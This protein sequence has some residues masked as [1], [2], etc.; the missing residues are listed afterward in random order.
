MAQTQ[1]SK[2]QIEGLVRGWIDGLAWQHE[3]RRA[4]TGGFDY[5]TA[6]EIDTLGTNDARELEGL[7]RFGGEMHADDQKRA[8]AGVLRGE[9]DLGAFE[10]IVQS[11]A[12]AI[13]APA[14]G[15]TLD[16]RLLTRTILRGYA[17]F[18]DEIRETV[19]SIPRQM[20][21][22]AIV[23]AAIPEFPL[24]QFWDD[25]ERHKTGRKEWK[26]DTAS[27]ARGTRNVFE[28]LFPGVTVAEVLSK[29]IASDFKTKVLALP[30]QYAQGKWQSMNAAQIA[31]DMEG[32]SI[33]TVHVKT[34]NKHFGNLSGYWQFLVEKKHISAEIKNPFEGYYTSVNKG[35]AARNERFNWPKQLEAKFFSAPW[36]TGC[37]SIYRR[38][39][40]GTEIHRDALLY[41]ASFDLFAA[42]ANFDGLRHFVLRPLGKKVAA[43]DLEDGI[44]KFAGDYNKYVGPLVSKELIEP[45]LCVVH[46]RYDLALGLFDLHAHCVWRVSPTNVDA[47]YKGIQ[48]KFSTVWMDKK[49]IRNP[50]ALVNYLVTWVV[51]HRQ[52]PDW[53]DDAL[54]ALWRASRPRL[55]RP[56]G[57]F[58]AFRGT[59]GDHRFVREGGTVKAIPVAKRR[60]KRKTGGAGPKTGAVVGF[61]RARLHG[62][63]RW[64]AIAAVNG[65]DRLSRKQIS[66]IVE[67]STLAKRRAKPSYPTTTTGLT[68][69]SPGPLP[70]AAQ[71]TPSSARISEISAEPANQHAQRGPI[72]AGSVVSPHIEHHKKV[73]SFLSF[74]AK[75]LA[76]TVARIYRSL[77]TRLRQPQGP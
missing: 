34:T 51:D 62:E 52:L 40:P 50:A 55:I 46:V 65:R 63:L 43:A 3:I 15:A 74:H 53:P 66:N 59:F 42:K 44:R 37:Q 23:P 18:L 1:F 19:A 75:R 7:L 29:P 6:A 72:G 48:T 2:V 36:I 60:A 68:P 22:A 12:R 56:A 31:K 4:E 71:M 21:S 25:F 27:N 30:R 32:K 67:Q 16:G 9:R 41:A 58:A 57:A 28:K 24:L 64:C 35:K 20:S 73:R 49:R 45:I 33:L 26:G 77:R 38:G 5:L 76:S 61:V 13:N 54:L 8:I 39:E 10:P 47:V 69:F 11:A 17:T 14:D 70:Q